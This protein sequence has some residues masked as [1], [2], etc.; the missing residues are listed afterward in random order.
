MAADLHCQLYGCRQ[1]CYFFDMSVKFG[2]TDRGNLAV[3][4]FQQ[5]F[6]RRVPQWHHNPMI[7]FFL[8][9]I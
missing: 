8:F 3:K 1:L 6:L 9:L 2:V 7:R 4:A 5:Y